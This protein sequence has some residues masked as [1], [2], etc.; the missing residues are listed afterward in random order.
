M[1]KSFRVTKK[2][3]AEAISRELT[4]KPLALRLTPGQ[5]KHIKRTTAVSK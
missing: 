1:A 4:K 3:A 2:Q 5:V